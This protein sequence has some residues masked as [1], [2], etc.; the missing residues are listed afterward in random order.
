MSVGHLLKKMAFAFKRIIYLCKIVE[1]L[2][3]C[4]IFNLLINKQFIVI[5]LWGGLEGSGGDKDILVRV[6][7]FLNK[8]CG[9]RGKFEYYVHYCICV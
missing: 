7:D 5:C 9:G 1:L 6:G 2:K 4:L 3:L 8:N